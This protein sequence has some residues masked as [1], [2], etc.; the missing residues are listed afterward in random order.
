MIAGSVGLG[1]GG[2]SGAGVLE[3]ERA[4]A[5]TRTLAAN[6]TR[7]RGE[8]CDQNASD[9]VVARLQNKLDMHNWQIRMQAVVSEQALMSQRQEQLVEELRTVVQDEV[10][11]DMAS[12]VDELTVRLSEMERESRV[13]KATSI[14]ARNET[15][16]LRESH[17]RAEKALEAVQREVTLAVTQAPPPQAVVTSAS[18]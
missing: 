2:G 13:M 8:D 5:G 16:E 7:W 6:R 18:L 11:A 15:V 14:A 4:P 17:T 10:M 9:G 12:K 3:A 1:G